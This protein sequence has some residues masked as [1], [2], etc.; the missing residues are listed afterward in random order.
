ME[1]QSITKL[2][3]K[4][5]ASNLLTVFLL[6]FF[7]GQ[8]LNS[9]TITVTEKSG[10]FYFDA[11][12][13]QSDTLGKSRLDVFV[14]VPY[15][16]MTFIKSGD[17]FGSEFKIFI[18]ISDKNDRV[19]ESRTLE[20]D[21]AEKNYYAT[22]GGNADF[23]VTQTVFYL[24]PGT[25][26]IEVVFFDETGHKSYSRTRSQTVID[27]SRYSFSLSGLML[28]SSIEEDKGKYIITPHIS[29]NIGI[30]SEY[31]FIFF[32]SYKDL[33]T[34]SGDLEEIDFV[35][36]LIN[37]N[38]EVEI[39][40]ERSRKSVS[41]A[42]NEH[43]LRVPIPSTL[44]Q[45]NYMLRLFALKPSDKGGFDEYDILATTERSI[46][47]MK[48]V[49]GNFISDINKAIKQ[50]RYIANQ[51]EMDYMLSPAN[52]QERQL[53]FEDFW[54]EHDPTP[55]TERDEAYE[56]YFYRIDYANRNFRS[57]TE[58]WRTDMGM[59]FVIYGPPLSIDKKRMNDGRYYE[60]WVYG[61][62]EII[63]VD[64]NGF[65]DYRLYSPMNITDK[66]KYH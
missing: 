63:F 62:H 45:G 3:R 25:Y 65:G 11:V 6:I 22:Q 17:V 35:Y 34:A 19:I 9:Q 4:N 31:F 51:S 36:Q 53:R 43:Y 41:D 14:M 55:N 21:I 58:G 57:Y 29:D 48:T 28:V 50:L 33:N 8:E 23:D 49:S 2:A 60:K 5:I 66:Y 26:E 10:L 24:L 40:S 30:L 59:V 18:K 64:Y 7:T 54:R 39:E 32:E 37:D 20:R 16:S 27:F 13:F 1:K 42:V 61:D 46:Q 15:A 12:L 44:P 38:N 52:E 47:N 56:Q